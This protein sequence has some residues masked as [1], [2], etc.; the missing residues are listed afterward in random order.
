MRNWLPLAVGALAF[1]FSG[2]GSA[3]VGLI[4]IDGPITPAAAD[5]VSRAAALAGRDADAC[6]IVQLNTPGGLL[7]S[8]QKIVRSFYES[9]VPVVVYVAPEGSG[10]AS[11]GCF[12]TL[13]ADVA[14]MAPHTNIGAA[15]PVSLGLGSEERPDDIMAGK[16]ESYAS[17]Y[18][19]TIAV[20][21][22]R[23]VDWAKSSVVASVSTTAEKALG[24]RVID[25]V[26]ADLPDLLRQLDGR[27]VRTE[28]L[29][30]RG[31]EV[32]IIPM[33]AREKLFQAIWQP[34]VMFVLLLVAIYG[35]I[36]EV[37][38]P[39]AVLPGVT[40]AVALVLVLYMGSVLP[41]D[42]AGVAL[43]VLAV[44]LFLT[45]AFAPTHGALTAG[46]AVCFFLGSLLLFDRSAPWLRLS[47]GLVL[48]ATVVTVG[49]FSLVVGAGLRAQRLPSRMG[50]EALIGRTVPAASAIDR[51]GGRVVLEG[52]SW[53]AVSETPVGAGQPVTIIGLEGL[54]LKVKPA[55][56]PSP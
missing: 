56:D 6:L 25:L 53:K 13:A 21:R 49:F 26:A 18:I 28:R 48:P 55:P 54:T 39:G 36:G 20:K 47:L 46:G 4:Q 23:N 15:H 42:I 32:R 38:S 45:D 11:A 34:E 52:E 35:L 33:L 3:R 19:E 7:D 5:Y 2:A 12:I 8:T 43:L 40:G 9:P 1:P 14:A 27:N 24:L 44:A 37:S 29:A 17:S 16:L 30:T 51:M 41:V 10:A 31:A 22:H 50:P